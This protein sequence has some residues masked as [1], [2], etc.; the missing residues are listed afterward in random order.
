MKRE[1]PVR[2]SPLSASSANPVLAPSHDVIATRAEALWR[3][4]GCPQGCD[5]ELWLEAERQVSY[6]PDPEGEARCRIASAN[7]RSDLKRENSMMKELNDLFPGPSG[8]ETT[9]L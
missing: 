2:L 3:A 6:L 8:K 1:T 9:S 7:E 5:N 4:R